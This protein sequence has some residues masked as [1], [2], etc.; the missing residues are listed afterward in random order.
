MNWDE[1]LARNL[2][3]HASKTKEEP[4]FLKKRRSA[5]PDA[6]ASAAQMKFGQEP[7]IVELTKWN[8]FV[9]R[10]NAQIDPWLE[11]ELKAADEAKPAGQY[12]PSYHIATLT[13]GGPPSEFEDT[14]VHEVGHAFSR[15]VNPFH[16]RLGQGRLG[17]FTPIAERLSRFAELQDAQKIVQEGFAHWIQVE[18]TGRDKFSTSVQ[19]KKLMTRVFD[20]FKQA[21]ENE[22]LKKIGIQPTRFP[23]GFQVM[24]APYAYGGYL[25]REAIGE[26]EQFGYSRSESVQ[27]L[28]RAPLYSLFDIGDPRKAAFLAGYPSKV[29]DS[30]NMNSLE[31]IAKLI[32]G[33]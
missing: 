10:L 3:E 11:Q 2:I 28:L 12:L 6:I 19:D 14:E 17:I 1:R 5:A 18:V 13:L 22:Q 26:M 21:S 16:L 25:V 27:R 8:R 23:D 30:V 32:C 33:T 31:T 7:D 9:L 15:N 20:S 24:F 29:P 4:W